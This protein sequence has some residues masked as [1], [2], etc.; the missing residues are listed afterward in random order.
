MRGLSRS[1]VLVRDGDHLVNVGHEMAGFVAVQGTGAHAERLV[2]LHGEDVG[3]RFDDDQRVD[4]EA[5][6]RALRQPRVE[7]WSGVVFG[8]METFDGLFLW[9]AT[10]LDRFCLLKAP[11]RERES[12]RQQ[13]CT[14]RSFGRM[15]RSIN[16]GEVT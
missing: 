3:L 9:L 15:L 14:S 11:P 6:R 13:W 10:S 4:T 12:P 2:T 8:G 7:K 1:L 5:L 16:Q